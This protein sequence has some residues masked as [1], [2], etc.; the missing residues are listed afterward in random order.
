LEVLPYGV[1][2]ESELTGLTPEEL[3]PHSRKNFPVRMSSQ[4]FT[5]PSRL[6]EYL[7]WHS[8]PEYVG[9]PLCVLGNIDRIIIFPEYFN[10]QFL[11]PDTDSDSILVAPPK[12]HPTALLGSSIR[13]LEEGGRIT[14]PPNILEWFSDGH[15]YARHMRYQKYG[16]V[17]E[18]F[19]REQLG[20]ELLQVPPQ[21]R[22]KL[23]TQFILTYFNQSRD[24]FTIPKKMRDSLRWGPKGAFEVIGLYD[25]IL[26]LPASQE[27]LASYSPNPKTPRA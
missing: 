4:R 11:M 3:V 8:D 20:S 24:S 16:D 25:R 23:S 21:G 18:I 17:L 13:Q 7:G 26:V 14:L 27:A 2:L 1:S 6:M 12:N 22:L 15:G 9:S 5:I 10:E 19:S